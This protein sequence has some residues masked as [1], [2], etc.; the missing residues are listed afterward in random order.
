MDP[1]PRA[2]AGG[3]TTSRIRRS[4]NG[5]GAPAVQATIAPADGRSLD[6]KRNPLLSLEKLGP[7]PNVALAEGE[8]EKN[9][10]PDCLSRW[11]QR[12]D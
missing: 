1:P 9:N 5:N 3:S 2:T 8:Q 10:L 6:D 4:G 12:K 7:A 11:R